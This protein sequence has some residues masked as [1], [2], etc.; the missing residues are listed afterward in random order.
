ME[1]RTHHEV[2]LCVRMHFKR[3]FSCC[4]CFIKKIWFLLY[5]KVVH[6]CNNIIKHHITTLE[7]YFIE[8]KW[9]QDWLQPTWK[10]FSSFSAW[11]YRVRT[12]Y[13]NWAKAPTAYHDISMNRKTRMS[14]EPEKLA[15]TMT[16]V[17]SHDASL[18]SC[19]PFL[20]FFSDYETACW[21]HFLCLAYDMMK[22]LLWNATI[23]LPYTFRV[24]IF[25]SER[26]DTVHG[27]KRFCC[28][29]STQEGLAKSSLQIWRNLGQLAPFPFVLSAYWNSKRGVW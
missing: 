24:I 4:H 15:N 14:W 16:N 3:F 20:L 2:R 8:N 23:Y 29:L 13:R 6:W 19:F 11:L 1:E 12:I 26:N 22:W 7:A 9:Q 27:K 21:Q 17:S 18:L 5:C 28:F 10:I 25:F